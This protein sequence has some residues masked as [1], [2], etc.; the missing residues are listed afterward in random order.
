MEFTFPSTDEIAASPELF[1][2]CEFIEE[3]ISECAQLQS[4]LTA[5]RD[6]AERLR[7]RVSEL[8]RIMFEIRRVAKFPPADP[9]IVVYAEHAL[10]TKN[11]EL[12]G[13]NGTRKSA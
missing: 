8:E 4:E 12:E 9:Q 11:T 5:A 10:R 1:R 3:A 7:G 13:N 6:E 2:A